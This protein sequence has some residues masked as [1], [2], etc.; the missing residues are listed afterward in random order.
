MCGGCKASDDQR[1]L[2][3]DADNLPAHPTQPGRIKRG[4]K[5]SP[6]HI[7]SGLSSRAP[8]T[9]WQS[10][11]DSTPIADSSSTEG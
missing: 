2:L 6:P 3:A 7:S 10:N 9:S 4:H 5:Q 11:S 8:S 1:A